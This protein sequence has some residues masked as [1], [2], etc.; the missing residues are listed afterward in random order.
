M[1]QHVHAEN[2]H[3]GLSK[4]LPKNRVCT[5]L[6]DLQTKDLKPPLSQ[7]NATIPT[8]EEVIK[9]LSE[10]NSMA[11]DKA[12]TDD[13]LRDAFELWWPKFEKQFQEALRSAPSPKAKVER[14][15]ED[16]T[17]EILDTV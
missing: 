5:F 8:K 1:F 4:G 14:T 9:L 3:D 6:V 13:R 16:M 17:S 7:F 2:A 10:I 11:K 15:L 12:L